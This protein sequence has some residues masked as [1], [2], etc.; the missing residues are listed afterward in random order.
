MVTYKTETALEAVTN[1]SLPLKPEYIVIKWLAKM[2]ETTNG[3][4]RKAHVSF[5]NPK[6]YSVVFSVSADPHYTSYVG[7]VAVD[8]ISFAV[9]PCESE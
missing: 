1:D 5:D 3:Q 6:D 2:S 9:G 8:E 7:Y 4:W